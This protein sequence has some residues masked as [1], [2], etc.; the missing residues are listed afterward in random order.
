MPFS[1]D[2]AGFP[3]VSLPRL[4]L[5]VQLFPVAK[6][7]LER[8]AAESNAFGDT[9]YGALLQVNP[10][11]SY[12]RFDAENREGLFLTGILP[13]EALA[14]AR[15]LGPGYDLPSVKEWRQ[16]Y[17]ALADEPAP[18]GIGDE[19]PEGP[20]RAIL[21]GLMAQLR[22]RTLL[23]LSLMH[24]GVVEWAGQE[25]RWVGLGAPRPSFQPNLWDPLTM[26]VRLVDP[27]AR[28]KYLGFRLVRRR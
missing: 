12:R 5:E 28:V 22:P 20:A 9:W 17:L 4:G 27:P 21:S 18:E 26:E 14:F 13:D 8:F 1:F 19:A 3:L 15:W 25:K 6:V 10:R 23:E 11:V 7:Q 16:V 24:G 2:R